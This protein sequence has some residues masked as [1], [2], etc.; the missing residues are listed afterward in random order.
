MKN[1][2]FSS[3]LLS[4][5]RGATLIVVLFLLLIIMVIG[6]Y[7][8]KIGITSLGI[9]TNAQVNQ[10]LAQSADTP[11]NKYLNTSDLKTLVSYSTAVGAALDEKQP[12]REFIFCYKPTINRAFGLNIDTSVIEA[13]ENGDDAKL[14]DSGISG[15]CNIKRDFGS[16]RQAVVTQVAIT[17]PK[18][19][20]ETK[21][22]GDNLVRGTNLALGSGLPEHLVSQQSIRVTTTSFLPAYANT[23]I[24]T[25]Q[26]NC[27]SSNKTYISDNLSESLTSKKTLKEC[28]SDYN[29]PVVSQVQEFVLASFLQQTVDP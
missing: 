9:S 24:D 29:I 2:Q 22:P 10:L 12:N 26:S 16:A 20:D 19:K 28:L 1:I 7:A 27:L 23:D 17:I 18:E 15:F 4:N 14:V 11:L 3:K 13:K 6:T 21:K 25:V 5:Q 8:I